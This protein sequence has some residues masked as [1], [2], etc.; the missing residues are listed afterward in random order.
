VVSASFKKVAADAAAGATVIAVAGIAGFSAGQSIALDAGANA[1][2]VVVASTAAGRGG[3]PGGAGGRGGNT[4]T[5]PATITVAAPL[6][7]AHPTGAQV[8]GT[9]ITLTTPLG[10]AHAAGAPIATSVPTPGAP[11]KYIRR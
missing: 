10:R 7:F 11:N 8:A 2:T 1:E 9:G 4:A 5:A 3:G 6:K